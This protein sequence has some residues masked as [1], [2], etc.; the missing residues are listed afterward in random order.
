[1][2]KKIYKYLLKMLF[3]LIYGKISLQQI[4]RQKNIKI[5]KISKL[6]SQKSKNKSYFLYEI[7]NGRVYTDNT[8]NVAIINGNQIIKN[9]SFQQKNSF[10]KPT[11]YNSTIKQGTPAIQ[12]KIKGKVLILCQGA[13]GINNYCHWLL[14]ILPKFR[15]CEEVYN[16]KDI[17][18]FYIQNKTVFQKE[19]LKKIGIPLNKIIDCGKYKHI[20]AD[21]II[22][23]THHVY[24][25][26]DYILNAQ[27]KQPEW[28]IIWLRKKFLKMK[29]NRN[30]KNRIFIDRSDSYSKHCQIINNEDVIK[31]FKKFNFKIYQ[32]SKLSFRQQ[33]KIFNDS[34]I[35]A[36][37]HGAGLTNLIFC[38][39][40]TKV[41]EIIQK[42]NP[43]EIYK[44]ISF[45]NKLKYQAI[46][47]DEVKN[48]RF[49]DI[50]INIKKL[51]KQIEYLI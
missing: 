49:G 35:I 43:N 47:V 48:N 17:D 34:K 37:A 19:S 3:F 29:N 13:S 7:K 9:I 33:I 46:K 8:E 42:P 51:Q 38:K 5:I 23:L 20:K 30:N 39:K 45:F 14:D 12:K 26:N 40:D 10:I 31:T 50:N 24:N 15:I 44:K 32:L 22:A 18:Y 41:L 16:L 6:K 21:K 36:G 2:L 28:S 25:K 27:K 4:N 11:K 1:M